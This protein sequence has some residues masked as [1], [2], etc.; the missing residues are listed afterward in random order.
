MCFFSEGFNYFKNF[1][2]EFL[3][4]SGDTNPRSQVPGSS[5]L[6]Y[7]DSLFLVLGVIYILKSKNHKLYLILGLLF[8]APIPAAITKENPH[9]L[10]SILMSPI[11]SA[12]SAI[13][14]YY[15][16][17]LFKNKKRGRRSREGGIDA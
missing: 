9:A 11:L 16:V 15:L 10:R 2:S 14:V 8:L 3:F 5:Q 1:S 6:Y 4:V 7:I 13:G 17:E 12:I